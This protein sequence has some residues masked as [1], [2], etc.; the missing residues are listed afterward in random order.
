MNEKELLKLTPGELIDL[1][2]CPT[3]FNH[4]HNGALYGDNSEKLI[5]EDKDIECFFVSNPRSDGHMCISTIQH[6]HDL[7][8]APDYINEKII[9]FAKQFIIIIKEVYH[10]ERVY[11]CTMCD[12]LNNH[13]HIQLIPRYSYE[14]RGSINFVKER[15]TYV[16][17]EEKLIKVKES[18]NEYVELKTNGIIHYQNKSNLI[19]SK[20]IEDNIPYYILQNILKYNC[21][22]IYTNY[23]SIIICYSNSPY[24]IW[25]WC[26]QP[27]HKDDLLLISNILKSDYISKGK[28]NFIL[29]EELLNELKKIDSIYNNLTLKMELLSYKL[30]K[31]NT[32]NHKSDGYMAQATYEDIDD[33]T[34]INKNSYFEIEGYEFSLKECKEKVIE[35]I[36]KDEL[37][38]WV[39]NENKIVS[40]TSKSINKN[41]VKVGSVYT[42]SQHRRKG[43]AINLVYQVTKLLLENHL[44]PILYTDSKY[45]A[46][47]ECYK[48]IGYQQIGK[49]LNIE[50]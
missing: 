30:T 16:Y 43:Y 3:C 24:P 22:D 38:V 6:Y 9:R 31:M 35:Q 23:K 41:Y 25:V 39:N 49:L 14:K 48:K 13:Y 28:Y 7:S 12:G 27:F 29:S 10:C 5:Y 8:E 19:A 20:L 36:K 34:I 44:I 47:N 4:K 15:H 17:D 37:Y 50:N 33:L 40:T 42:L 46:S 1:G 32:I 26:K 18:I 45:E 11:M 2:I 21:K